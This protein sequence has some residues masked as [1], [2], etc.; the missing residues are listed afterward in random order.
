MKVYIVDDNQ[1]YIDSLRMFIEGHLHYSV[2][3]IA[4]NGKQF[5]DEYNG[6]A[7]VILMDINMP[8]LNG[9]RATK[10]SFWNNCELK[11]LAVSQYS[12]IADLKQLV[13]AGFKGFV[14]KTNI[15]SELKNAINAVYKGEL[16][17]PEQLA[18]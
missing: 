4:F 14:S 9:L 1:K 10:L 15:F 7:D 12:H 2:V 3:G 13:E 8:V 18:T 11:V 16:Y 6:T 5:I 17:F